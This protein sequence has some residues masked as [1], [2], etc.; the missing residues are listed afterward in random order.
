MLRGGVRIRSWRA[1]IACIAVAAGALWAPAAAAAAHGQT[2]VFDAPH[3][4]IEN[5]NGLRDQTLD[6]LRALGVREIRV[7]MYWKAVAPSPGSTTKPGGAFNASDPATYP[8][9]K[10]DPYDTLLADAKARGF[11]VLL[12]VS[13]PVPRWASSTHD[14]RQNPRPG[15]FYEFVHAVGTRYSGSYRDEVLGLPVGAPL[16]DVDVWSLWNEPNVSYFLG[17]Q[18]K[19]G[20]PYAPRLYR[21]L[22]IR[23]RAALVDSGDGGDPIL[24]G[25]TSPRGSSR[26]V[27]PLAFLRGTLCLSATYRR[28]PSCG[29]LQADGWATHPYSWLRSPL[30]RPRDR[31]D[32]TISSLDRLETALDRAGRA[33]ALPPHLPV[34]ITEYG[35]QSKPDPYVGVSLAQQAEFDALSERIAWRDHRV[36]S[37]AQYLMRDDR[38]DNNPIRYGGFE[39]GLRF[40]NGH[41]KPSYDEFRTPLTIRRSGDRVSFWGLVRPA[42]GSTQAV[43]QAKDGKRVRTVKTVTTGPTGY[44]SGSGRF[45]SGRRWRLVW[46]SLAGTTFKG[47]WT[48]AY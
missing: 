47:P 2:L 11:K 5:Q 42:T 30:V 23:G 20:K 37:F 45:R 43:I 8:A 34:Y 17:P 18:F 46:T 32:V 9:S 10:W 13:G 21:R 7:L 22:F 26:S 38:P 15:E 35:V 25:E 39:S 29:R 1:L 36:R 27:A 41:K 14:Q 24:I 6:E 4:L 40:S 19:D 12:T 3:E 44:L 33:G 16:P 31:D 48:H 28:D